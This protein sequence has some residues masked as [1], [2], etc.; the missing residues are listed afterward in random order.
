VGR[1][2]MVGGLEKQGGSASQAL[3]ASNVAL[4]PLD[5]CGSYVNAL[6][7]VMRNEMAAQRKVALER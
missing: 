4:Q 5:S 6:D 1:N 7:G 2:G 3:K